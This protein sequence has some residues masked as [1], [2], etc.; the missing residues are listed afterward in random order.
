MGSSCPQSRSTNPRQSSSYSSIITTKDWNLKTSSTT[1]RILTTIA[2]R[3]LPSTES[4][5]SLHRRRC[6]R[7]LHDCLSAQHWKATMLP[8]W[9]MDRLAR[10][11]HSQW[12]D[13]DT[14]CVMSS[15]ASFLEPSRTSSNTFRAVTMNK[16]LSWLG[17]VICKSITKLLVTC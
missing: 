3:V 4:T 8:S 9:L 6:I 7:R 12:R 14:I 16:P 15:E 11:R 5:K 2:Y 1:W 13:S 17:Q 10:G